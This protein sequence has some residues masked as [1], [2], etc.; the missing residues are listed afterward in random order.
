MT[1]MRTW[2]TEEL[3][4]RLPAAKLLYWT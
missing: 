2:F 1:E 4:R 3:E